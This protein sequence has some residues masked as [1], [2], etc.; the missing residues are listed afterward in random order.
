MATRFAPVSP[1]VVP[2]FAGVSTFLRLP[3]HDDPNDVDCM[4][5]GV[6]FDGGT[7]F[8]PGARFGPRGVREASALS[9]G[10]HPES[11]VQLFDHLRC[12]D[13]G[14]VLAVPMDAAGTLD[15]VAERAEA[16]ARAGAVTAFVGG[17]HLCTLGVLRGLARVYGP[18]G[19]VHVDAHSDTY[20]PAWG[21]DPHHG[22]VFRNA[23][24]EGLLRPGRVLQL[25]IRG[26]FSSADDLKFAREAGFDILS[27]EAIHRD[28]D[29]AL[30]RVAAL[31]DGGPFYVS[32]DV[33]GVDPSMAPGTGTPVPG[34]LFSWQALALM[35]ATA[36][37]R[38]VGCDV[39]EIAPDL[40]LNNLTSLL[41]A[42][43]LAETLAAVALRRAQGKP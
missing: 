20:P 13:G 40:D 23:V 27:A 36:A 9:R 4:I 5:V 19:L 24:E 26:P 42:N 38:V 11:G 6:P 16:I 30:A 1:R 34:G 32:F 2:R 39:M 18:V 8:R 25:G 7:T 12:C 14:D 17:D 15:R 33:D 3:V 22:T 21:V 28:L 37:L 41:A 31:D 10:Y 35:R 43:V 29:A